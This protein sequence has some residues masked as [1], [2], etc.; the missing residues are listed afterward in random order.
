MERNVSKSGEIKWNQEKKKWN[1]IRRN[2]YS[3][4]SG[5]EKK[6]VKMKL[7]HE[8]CV[9][10]FIIK[11]KRQ[12]EREREREREIERKWE[13]WRKKWKENVKE[14]RGTERIIK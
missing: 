14:N 2:K 13:R 12:R 11:R 1:K 5:E 3:K 9:V 7:N 4:E 8:W 10:A 6:I